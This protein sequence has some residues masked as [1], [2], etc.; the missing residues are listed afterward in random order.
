MFFIAFSMPLDG[1]ETPT[2][3]PPY[4]AMIIEERLAEASLELLL[5]LQSTFGITALVAPTTTETNVKYWPFGAIK[6]LGI[7]ET[8]T[9]DIDAD[10]LPESV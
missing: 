1:T 10:K 6:L 4:E 2:K 5:S 3:P 8:I 7:T 9:F